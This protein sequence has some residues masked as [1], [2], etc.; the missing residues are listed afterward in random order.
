MA[1]DAP[2]PSP[3]PPPSRSSETVARRTSSRVRSA[4]YNLP[5]SLR[6]ANSLR[7][8]FPLGN[9]NAEDDSLPRFVPPTTIESREIVPYGNPDDPNNLA[10]ERVTSV[11]LPES[12]SDD[13]L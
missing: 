8:N 1:I 13:D 12:E 11:A 5:N 9:I 10:L 6:N 7:V 3:T 4:P 2:P